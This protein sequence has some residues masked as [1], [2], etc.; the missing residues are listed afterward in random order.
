[1][2]ERLFRN[3]VYGGTLAGLLLI[4]L[5]PLFLPAL[6]AGGLYGYLALVA[7]MLH[8]YEE[9][10]DDRFRRFVNGRV[11]VGRRGLSP[12]DVFVINVPGVWG[13][14]ALSIWLAER[15]APGWVLIAAWL[16]VVNA[17]AHGVQG[18][19]MRQYNPGLVTAVVLF[20]PLGG[21]ILVSIWP[22]ATITENAV[23]LGVVLLIHAGILFRA[24][25]GRGPA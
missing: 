16:M 5:G 9:H 13:V 6:G 21:W 2:M 11:A 7:Y 18:V 22:V 4:V 3:W 15:A 17:F 19:L 8:Q 24:M 10:D 14:I 1:M 20:V 23:S 25:R 12:A